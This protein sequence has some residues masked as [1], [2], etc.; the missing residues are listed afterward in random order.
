LYWHPL[1]VMI[2]VSLADLI[3]HKILNIGNI[4]VLK[5]RPSNNNEYIINKPLTNIQPEPHP[6]T[7]ITCNYKTYI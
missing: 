3:F 5:S 4:V 7:F 2:T 1:K 6:Y